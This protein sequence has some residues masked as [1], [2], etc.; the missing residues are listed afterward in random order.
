[1]ETIQQGAREVTLLLLAAVG[2]V[3]L[4]LAHCLTKD[5][6]SIIVNVHNNS[7]QTRDESVAQTIL[8][9]DESEVRKD[10]SGVS[11]DK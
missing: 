11:T 1:M 3:V 7:R 5:R 8:V 6:R 9:D 10:S 2:C 4:C